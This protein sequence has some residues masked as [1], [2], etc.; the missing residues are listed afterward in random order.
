MVL[1]EKITTRLMK[2][3]NVRVSVGNFMLEEDSDIYNSPLKYSVELIEEPGEFIHIGREVIRWK[4]IGRSLAD[5][6]KQHKR[7]RKRAKKLEMQDYLMHFLNRL[8]EI[9]VMKYP[10]WSLLNAIP[11]FP[12]ALLNLLK[13]IYKIGSSFM[14]FSPRKSRSV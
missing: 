11:A 10:V 5:L 4:E 3:K 1:S 13:K 6:E 14:L 9:P 7:F 8:A 12:Y 2:H